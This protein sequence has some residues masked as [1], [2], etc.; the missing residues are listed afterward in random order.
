MLQIHLLS[1]FSVTIDDRDVTG[2]EASKAQETLAYLLI[3]RQRPHSR[4]VLIDQIWGDYTKDQAQKGLRQAL[5][6]LQN[7]LHGQDS[8]LHTGL[9]QVDTTWVQISVTSQFWLDIAVL[10]ECYERVQGIRGQL[11]TADQAAAVTDAVQLYQG[12]LL[13]TCYQDW[14]LIERERLQHIDL[15]LLDKLMEYEETQGNYEKACAYGEQI[16]RHDRAR[17]QTHRRLM[18][19]YCLAGDRTA[20]LRQYEACVVALATELAVKPAKQTEALYQAIKADTLAYP[21]PAASPTPP[22]AT[23]TSLPSLLNHLQQVQVALADLQ[24]NVAQDIQLLES[25]LSP[26]R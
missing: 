17:E 6:Q 12:D 10:E 21:S 3:H 1:K 9:L 20:A 2:L 14:C 5:W 4:E 16:L 8:N 15:S 22:S 13:E 18:R 19:L 11:L 7:A 26:S 25:L 24:R 23:P